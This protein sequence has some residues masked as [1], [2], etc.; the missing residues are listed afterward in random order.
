MSRRIKIPKR[1]TFKDDF[2]TRK[3]TARV[4]PIDT[5]SN[6]IIRA[7]GRVRAAR[8]DHYCAFPTRRVRSR[9]SPAGGAGRTPSLSLPRS[10][11][12]HT[13]RYFR[14]FPS[15]GRHRLRPTG[16]RTDALAHPAEVT[17]RLR[18]VKAVK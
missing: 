2:H 6:T 11:H 10:Q 12:T 9:P 17:T 15:A 8:S 4:F 3:S 1:A 7:L 13:A 18:R 14:S 16:V 5:A